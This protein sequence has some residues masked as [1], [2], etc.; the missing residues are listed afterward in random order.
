MKYP[1]CGQCV[2]FDPT[3]TII[4]ERVTTNATAYHDVDKLGGRCNHNKHSTRTVAIACCEFELADIIV[5]P[6]E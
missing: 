1:T 6:T 2:Y 5:S 4:A 3:I